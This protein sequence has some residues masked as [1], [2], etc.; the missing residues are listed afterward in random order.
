MTENERNALNY[1]TPRPTR[2]PPGSLRRRVLYCIS[3]PLI[4][5]GLAMSQGAG[6]REVA[7]VIA[8]FGALL[9]GFA[10]PLGGNGDGR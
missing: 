2:P 1:E 7:A 10:L 5:L 9:L 3:L 4:V 6:D 8:A